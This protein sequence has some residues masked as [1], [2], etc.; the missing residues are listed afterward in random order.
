MGT[1]PVITLLV[2]ISDVAFFRAER[3]FIGQ[4]GLDRL[5]GVLGTGRGYAR[6]AIRGRPD[7]Q[8]C[9]PPRSGPCIRLLQ[10]GIFSFDL[11]SLVDTSVPT[12]ACC[13]H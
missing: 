7:R 3:P 6:I 10:Q 4:Q 8:R 11:Q 5:F 12:S 1:Q 9:C 13:P 2:T